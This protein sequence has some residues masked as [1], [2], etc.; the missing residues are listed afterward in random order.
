M[1]TLDGAK[2]DEKIT[3]LTQITQLFS[4]M[5]E[6]SIILTGI[7]DSSRIFRMYPKKGI[8]FLRFRKKGPSL[9][10]HEKNKLLYRVPINNHNENVERFSGNIGNVR[11]ICRHSTAVYLLFPMGILVTYYFNIWSTGLQNILSSKLFCNS[12]YSKDQFLHR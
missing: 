11:R 9:C 6:L 10:M 2:N 3:V 1:V 7:I 4:H 8:F 12:Y 5:R